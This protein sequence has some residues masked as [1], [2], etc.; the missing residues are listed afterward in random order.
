[1][2]RKGLLLN[3]FYTLKDQYFTYGKV[4]LALMVLA[5]LINISSELTE[6]SEVAYL[7]SPFAIFAMSM[8]MTLFTYEEKSGF[9]KYAFTTPVTRKSYLQEKYLFSLFNT[10]A[11]ILVGIVFLLMYA[12]F[13][14]YVPTVQDISWMLLFS[15]GEFLVSMVMSIWVI[16]LN[17]KFGIA[18][19]RSI[20]LIAMVAV[21]IVGTVSVPASSLTAANSFPG[22]QWILIAF[23]F[24]FVAATVWMFCMSFRWT[25]RK[26][27]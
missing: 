16:A 1:M 23:L 24:L 21:V 6:L 17:M 12:L 22:M 15:G 10:T 14:K 5:C 18:K 2:K 19:A 11:G 27:L 20:L 7:M 9:M 8:M 13:H 25:E 3:D 26:E 4:M